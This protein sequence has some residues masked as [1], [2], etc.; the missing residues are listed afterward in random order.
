MDAYISR[1]CALSRVGHRHVHHQELCALDGVWVA[2]AI[3]NVGTLTL[4]DSTVSGNIVGI[5]NGGTLTL[6]GSTVSGNENGW[7]IASNGTLTLTNSTVSGDAGIFIINGTVT[8]LNSTVSDAIEVQID[9]RIPGGSATIVSTATLIDGACTTAAGSMVTWT[10]NGYNIES[11]GDTC[12][13]DP[14]GT[15]Q[16]SVS[17]EALNLESL[18]TTVDRR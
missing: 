2:G 3:D 4:T 6:T 11:P 15:D 5:D 18:L 16:V 1:L 9:D 12:G 17:P 7:G 14:D 8:L 13:F 10:S